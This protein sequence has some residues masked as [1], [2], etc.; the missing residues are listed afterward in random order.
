[1]SGQS[2]LPPVDALLTLGR[3]E[4]IGR[5][6]WRRSV[7]AGMTLDHVPELIRLLEDPE[8]N[9]ESVDDDRFYAPIHA[10]RAIGFFRAIDAIDPLIRCLDRRSKWKD[11][12]DW[13][14]AEIPGILLA[15]GAQSLPS[16]MKSVGDSTLDETCR[17]VIAETMASFARKHPAHRDTVVAAITEVAE[18]FEDNSEETNTGLVVALLELKVVEAAPLLRRIFHADAVNTEIV[19]DWSDVRKELSLERLPDDPPERAPGAPLYGPDSAIAKVARLISA[20]NA[21]E[22]AA[23][24]ERVKRS[25][26]WHRKQA[27]KRK[28]QTRRC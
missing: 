28:Q 14:I 18:Q 10:W 5:A 19:G 7:I 25:A 4:G 13:G 2:Y 16:L 9:D 6:K 12:D 22:P 21:R 3:P 8:F 27:K 17:A 26:K 1:M 24:P 15:M 23:A 20:R 11:F